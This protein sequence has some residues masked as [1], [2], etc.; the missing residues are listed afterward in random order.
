MEVMAVFSD[1]ASLMKHFCL[2]LEADMAA[3]RR[4]SSTRER[5][6]SIKRILS[7]F[8]KKEQ[9]IL[10]TY[11]DFFGDACGRIHTNPEFVEWIRSP[12]DF[13]AMPDIFTYEILKLACKITGR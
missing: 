8:D 5:Q 4:S 6:N 12:K 11:W 2:L 13:T 3:S 1:S 7:Q 10:L 9:D